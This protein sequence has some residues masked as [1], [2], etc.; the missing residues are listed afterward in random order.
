MS[1][2][3][4]HGRL[5]LVDLSSREWSTET[6]PQEYYE[7]L[8]GGRGVAA[9]YYF[10][11]IGPAVDPLG[12]DNEMILFTGPLTGVGIPAGQAKLSTRSPLTGHYLCSNAGGNLGQ[13]EG[14]GLTTPHRSR[15]GVLIPLSGPGRRYPRWH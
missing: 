14:R 8:L 6:V 11:R 13:A 10:D 5:L 12:E 3:G 15:K 4:F 1:V 9:R 2:G 7:A